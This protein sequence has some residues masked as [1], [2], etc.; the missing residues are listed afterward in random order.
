MTCR[1]IREYLFAFLDNELDTSLSIE[2]QRHLERCCDC[3][4]EAEIEHVVRKQLGRD[5]L[6]QGQFPAINKTQLVRSLSDKST[7]SGES[8]RSPRIWLGIA[9]AM[10]LLASAAARFTYLPRGHNGSALADMLIDDF[11]R[12]LAEDSPVQVASNDAN[13]VSTWLKSKTNIEVEVPRMYGPN[14][15]LVGA[16]KCIISGRPAALALYELEGF[17]AS[18]VAMPAAEG[19]L[20]GMQSSDAGHSVDHCKGHTVVARKLGDMMYFAV[21]RL[22]EAELL[23]LIPDNQETGDMRPAPPN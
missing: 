22:S 16:R 14:Y 11:N 10:L 5:L 13:E 18:M 8:K 17:P 21:G 15:K 12:V 9:A 23:L 19:D 2:V 3:A 1:E 4:R 7:E 6:G 20:D